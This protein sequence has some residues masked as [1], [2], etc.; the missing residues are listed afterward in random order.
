[1]IRCMMFFHLLLLRECKQEGK[2]QPSPPLDVT[3]GEL[4][5]EVERALAQRDCNLHKNSKR[6]SIV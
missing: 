6:K 1:M 2:V 3:N 4:V 5:Y